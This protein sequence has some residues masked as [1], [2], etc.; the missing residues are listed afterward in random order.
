[1]SDG[2]V[3]WL[4]FLAAVHSV[5]RPGILGGLAIEEIENC[6]HP[7]MQREAMKILREMCEAY[8]YQVVLLSTHSETILNCAK[9]EEVLVC[10]M[11][12]GLTRVSRASNAKELSEAIK[13]SGFG[14]GYFFTAGA[15]ED[16]G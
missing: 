13:E 12:D 6:L 14:L 15:I 4:S 16:E 1:M 8:R 9:P 3:K 2:T 11:Q 5:S 7:W 10:R